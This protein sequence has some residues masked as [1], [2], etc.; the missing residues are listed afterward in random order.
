MRCLKNALREFLQIWHKGPLGLKDDLCRFPPTACCAEAYNCQAVVLVQNVAG[1]PASLMLSCCYQLTV[2][3]HTHTHTF[4]LSIILIL[5]NLAANITLHLKACLL[6]SSKT[7]GNFS[8][9]LVFF[10]RTKSHITPPLCQRNWCH[11]VHWCHVWV[12]E[13]DAQ[14][15]K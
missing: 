2:N 10:W 13:Q 4:T 12:I 11:V 9:S 15:H 5:F 8:F 14:L 6:P 1:S 7:T 3:T